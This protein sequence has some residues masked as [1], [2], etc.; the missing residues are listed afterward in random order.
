M[1]P[2]RIPTG[3]AVALWSAAALSVTGYTIKSYFATIS[4]T[5]GAGIDQTP[6]QVLT[7][8][9]GNLINNALRLAAPSPNAGHPAPL[10]PF[11]QIP[12]IPRVAPNR[13]K[14]KTAADLL[15]NSANSG[16]R[17]NA[18][19]WRLFA[20]PFRSANRNQLSP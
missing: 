1:N 12:G 2:P 5:G 10:V 9:S 3:I 11:P 18:K 4:G 17:L 6:T 8:Q 19:K 13:V 16:K 14:P 20:H 15:N 7:D